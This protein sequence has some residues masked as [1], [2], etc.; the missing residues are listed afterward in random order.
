MAG[1]TTA[2]GDGGFVYANGDALLTLFD[3]YVTD[4]RAGG[5]GGLALVVMLSLVAGA[6]LILRMAFILFSPDLLLSQAPSRRDAGRWRIQPS[7]IVMHRLVNKRQV[8]SFIS[9]S[10]DIPPPT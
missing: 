3:V 6:G 8:F 1:S 9:S 2:G 5:S 10:F 4:A 7:R